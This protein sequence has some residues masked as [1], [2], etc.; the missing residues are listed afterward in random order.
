MSAEAR[1]RIAEAQKK[2]R[3]L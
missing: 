2:R 1:A 3:A